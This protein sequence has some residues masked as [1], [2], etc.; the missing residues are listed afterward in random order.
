MVE[1]RVVVGV[2]WWGGCGG[3]RMVGVGWVG[4]CAWVG[5]GRGAYKC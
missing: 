5:V 1:C 4:V 3:C 2:G